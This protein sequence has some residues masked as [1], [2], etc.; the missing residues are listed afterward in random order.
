MLLRLHTFDL[1][2]AHRFATSR[3]SM[4][5][6]PTLVVELSQDGQSGFGE[7]T[8]NRYHRVSIDRMTADLTVLRPRLESLRFVDPAALWSDV[9]PALADNAFALCALDEAA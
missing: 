7:A 5:S 1:P 3:G 9:Q 6:Q 4:K 2:L 8:S